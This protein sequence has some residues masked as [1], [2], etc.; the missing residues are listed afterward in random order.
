[1]LD[2]SKH[3]FE[4]A[5]LDLIVMFYD[6]DRDIC[7][8]LHPALKPGGFLSCKNR[9]AWTPYRGKAMPNLRP[10]AK[11]EIVALLPKLQVVMHNERSVGDRGVVEFVGRKSNDS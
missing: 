7:A 4:V 6:C 5:S 8:R 2:A 3:Q 1:M 9:I 10:L 11:G